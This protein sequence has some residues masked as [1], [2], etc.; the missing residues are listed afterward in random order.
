MVSVTPHNRA[1]SL[2]SL[3][4]IDFLID[5]RGGCATDSFFGFQDGKSYH[6][7]LGFTG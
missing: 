5:L 1:I 6:V 4:L 7:A 2:P 3:Q